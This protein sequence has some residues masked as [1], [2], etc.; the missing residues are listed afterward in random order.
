[1]NY[2]ERNQGGSALA[3]IAGATVILLIACCIWYSAQRPTADLVLAASYA[4]RN[5]SYDTVSDAVLYRSIDLRSSVGTSVNVRKRLS[6]RSPYVFYRVTVFLPKSKARSGGIQN[7]S[8]NY[9]AIYDFDGSGHLVER[10]FG[11]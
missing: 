5:E 8:D 4:L 1:M 2:S 11:R 7:I 9:V 3:V 6:F 10:S